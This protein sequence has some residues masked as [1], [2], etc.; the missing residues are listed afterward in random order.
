MQ[1]ENFGYAFGYEGEVKIPLP[2]E[3]FPPHALNCF[4]VLYSI[5][6]PFLF[7]D[8]SEWNLFEIDTLVRISNGGFC[9]SYY[10]T[11]STIDYGW[12]G[13][14]QVFWFHIVCPRAVNHLMSHL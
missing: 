11:S 7:P 8:L 4:F 12:T 10:L 14:E 3:K 9:Y 13:L 6:N 5:W 1:S 2:S